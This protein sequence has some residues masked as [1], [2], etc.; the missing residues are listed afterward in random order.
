LAL[1]ASSEEARSGDSKPLTAEDLDEMLKRAA[2]VRTLLTECGLD[3]TSLDDVVR[4][5]AEVRR[6]RGRL[7][8]AS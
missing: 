2:T 8:R 5:V 4:L 1:S 6:L 3:V 7:D